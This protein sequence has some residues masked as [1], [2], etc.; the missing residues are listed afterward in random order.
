MHGSD[1]SIWSEVESVED[2]QRE[3]ERLSGY[4]KL[5]WRSCYNIER[6]ARG[7]K[8]WAGENIGPLGVLDTP[9][10][11]SKICYVR[12]FTHEIHNICNIE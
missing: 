9:V 12:V 10:H 5:E 7:V 3:D 8:L 1:A 11:I 4:R 2:L 6:D